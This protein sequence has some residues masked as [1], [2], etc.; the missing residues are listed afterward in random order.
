MPDV[1]AVWQAEVAGLRV[2]ASL[3]NLARPSLKLKRDGDVA[4]DSAGGEIS[5]TGGKKH[6]VNLCRDTQIDNYST[7][8]ENAKSYVWYTLFF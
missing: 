6:K 1:L 5:S 7:E 8:T 4:Q 3:G 2:Q